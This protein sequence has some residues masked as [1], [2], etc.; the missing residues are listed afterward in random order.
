M[1]LFLHVM[2]SSDINV[3]NLAFTPY[4]GVEV[5]V[6]VGGGGS[7]RYNHSN[8]YHDL[9]IGYSI[10]CRLVLAG[11]AVVANAFHSYNARVGTCLHFITMEMS[12]VVK[13]I[14]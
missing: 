2:L 11:G 10:S 1:F 5:Y 4:C 6:C 9:A 3:K 12:T 8:I 14:E 13:N 7:R